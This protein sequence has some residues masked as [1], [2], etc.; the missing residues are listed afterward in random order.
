MALAKIFTDETF[1]GTM[2]ESADKK[3]NKW[4]EQNCSSIDIKDVR[5]QHGR[6]EEDSDQII[7]LYE[8]I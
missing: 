6:T 8:K 7:V 4:V 1:M 2:W 3:F 5:I